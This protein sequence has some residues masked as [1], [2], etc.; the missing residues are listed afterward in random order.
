MA[1]KNPL[2]DLSTDLDIERDYVLIDGKECHIKDKQEFNMVD[3]YKLQKWGK[4][5]GS[6]FQKEDLDESEFEE[7]IETTDKLLEFI[8]IDTDKKILDKLTDGQ[9][10][11]IITAFTKLLTANLPEGAIEAAQNQIAEEANK[12]KSKSTSE[13][14]LQ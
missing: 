8:F 4:R 9:K 1:K 7:F 11:D 10:F 12:Q 14:G 13:T 6:L 2:L 5:M 3:Y